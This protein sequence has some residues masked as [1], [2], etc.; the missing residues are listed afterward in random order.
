[1]SNNTTSTRT[2]RVL[3]VDDEKNMRH[4]LANILRREGYPVTAAAT[5]EEAVALC[6]Q[7]T[8]DVILL[9]VRMP[10]IDGVETFRR[11]RRHQEGV[12]VIMMSAYTVDELKD[13]ALDEGAVAFL[14]KPLDIDQLIKLVSEVRDTAILVVEDEDETIALLDRTLSDQG[15]KVT[16]SRS[17]H[18]ALELVE[19]I[20]FDL[21]FIDASLPAMSGLDLYVAIRRINPTAVAIMMTGSEEEFLAIAKEAVRRTAYTFLRKPLDIDHTLDLLNRITS[22]RVSDALKKP[23]PQCG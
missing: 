17:P 11:I 13:I 18:D 16:V 9:D 10:G 3:I 23:P 7:F 6:D 15:Y 2:A 12:R 20:R 19:Q 14:S 4:T 21:I 8:Y 5:G 22:Q 1:M